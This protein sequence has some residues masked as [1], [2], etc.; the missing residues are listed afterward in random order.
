MAEN[1]E[2]RASRE[3]VEAFVRELRGFYG[4]LKPVEQHMLA[5]ILE[6]A[7][8]GETASYGVRRIFRYGDPEEGGGSGQEESSSSGWNDLV[9][10]IEEQGED[11]TQ[12]F[13][14]RGRL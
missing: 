12:G 9:G 13:G 3:E 1:Q 2:I 8:A 10:W 11:D 7:Q 4:G 6:G 14:M 5:T